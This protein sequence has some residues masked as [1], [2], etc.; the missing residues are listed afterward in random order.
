MITPSLFL[1][2]VLAII[3]M[4]DYSHHKHWTSFVAYVLARIWLI[5]L[6]F[7]VML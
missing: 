2:G 6:A 1:A 7:E 5:C 4:I 3:S